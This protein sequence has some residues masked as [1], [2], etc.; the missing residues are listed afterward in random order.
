MRHRTTLQVFGVPILLGIAT[1]LGLGAGLI[2]DGGWDVAAGL[3]LAA[4]L[5]ITG[6]YWTRTAPTNRRNRT[7]AV[8]QM[9]AVRRV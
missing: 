9:P 5:A 7:G 6:W 1:L 2:G 4:P 8:H 3:L